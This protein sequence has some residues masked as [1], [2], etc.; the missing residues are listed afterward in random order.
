MET[1]IEEGVAGI[2]P[3]MKTVTTI[4]ILSARIKE[5]GFGDV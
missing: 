5:L 1:T 3:G 4:G 2:I